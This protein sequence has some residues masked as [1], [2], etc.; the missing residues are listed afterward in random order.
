MSS[1]LHVLAGFQSRDAFSAWWSTPNSG[2]TVVGSSKFSSSSVDVAFGSTYKQ[3]HG[4][5]SRFC[6]AQCGD[7]RKVDHQA[8]SC[9][10]VLSKIHLLRS[11]NF[12]PVTTIY[13]SI[14][15]VDHEVVSIGVI[16]KFIIAEYLNAW[17]K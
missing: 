13:S 4:I 7:M 1:V 11:R 3:F 5:F 12:S 15:L 9:V 2:N 8:L 16:M 17:I 6:K 14:N 10:K